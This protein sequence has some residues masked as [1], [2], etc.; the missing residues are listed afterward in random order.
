[1]KDQTTS[2]ATCIGGQPG[3]RRRRAAAFA[4]SAFAQEPS[5]RV[6]RLDEIIVTARKVEENLQ[7]TPIAI[8]AITGDALKDRQVFRTEML[9]QLVPNLQFAN[10]APLAGNNSSSALFIRGIGQTDPT[11]TVDPGVGLYIDDVY[12]GNA[13][14]GSMALRD[15]A[16]IQVLRGPQGTLFGRNTIGGAVIITTTDPGDEFGGKVRA[17][18]GDD[19]LIDGF[20][21]LDVPLGEK[22]KT[23]SSLGMRQQDGYVT[24]P[25]GTDLGDTDT[26]TGSTKWV[27]T[28]NDASAPPS[29]STT[30]KSEENGA[31]LVFAAMNE[32][33]TFPRVASLDAGCPGSPT[34]RCRRRASGSAAVPMTD[35]PR[36]AN[37]FQGAGP[38]RQQRHAAAVQ[39][40]RQLG[41]LAQ[42]VLRSHRSDDPQVHHRVSRGG[43]DRRA[44]C[45]QHAAA[46]SS[47]PTTT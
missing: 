40:V 21:A 24:R 8:T 33:A 36:C 42:S 20:V 34:A 28:P 35:D 43:L 23:R 12:I 2:Q 30:T 29:S 39:Q 16:N 6:S 32:A 17:E 26:F 19:S 31:P 9:D 41:R 22:F 15:I 45:R 27:W 47:T 44:R 1:M 25:D 11:S 38:L 5:G 3:A 7:E 4:P 14:G 13:V 37:D 18:L 46:R 10:N